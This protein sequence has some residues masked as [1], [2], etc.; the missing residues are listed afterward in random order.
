MQNTYATGDGVGAITNSHTTERTDA[1]IIWPPFLANVM[2]QPYSAAHWLAS[3]LIGQGL[4]AEVWDV[5]RAAFARMLDRDFLQA[6]Y[7]SLEARRSALEAQSSLSPD[8]VRDYNSLVS[9]LAW[10]RLILDNYEECVGRH[11]RD[12]LLYQENVPAVG[13]LNQFAQE[14]LFAS[15]DQYTEVTAIMRSVDEIRDLLR[16][17]DVVRYREFLRPMIREMI[18]TRRPRLVGLSFSFQQ[19]ALSCLVLAHE[20]AA[21]DPTIHVTIGGQIVSYLRR[22]EA[23]HLLSEDV[24]FHSVVYY[25]GEDALVAMVRALHDGKPPPELPNVWYRGAPKEGPERPH[26]NPPPPR[27]H[28]G[29]YRVPDAFLAEIPRAVRDVAWLP[30]LQAIGCYW[31]RC[32]FCDT[33]TQNGTNAL[34]APRAEKDILADIDFYYE[35]GFRRFYIVTDS[36][37]PKPALTL[38]KAIL[39]RGIDIKWT[40]FFKIDRRWD[41]ET[42][43]ALAQAGY[44]MPMVGMEHANDRVLKLIDKGYDR[45]GIVSFFDLLRQANFPPASILTILNLPTS[46]REEN[47]EV[48]AFVE[49]HA[50]RVRRFS[51]SPFEVVRNTPMAR[52]PPAFGFR[53]ADDADPTALGP[54]RNTIVLH[55]YHDEAGMTAEETLEV[56]HAFAALIDRIVKKKRYGGQGALL[57]DE[58]ALPRFDGYRFG[59][60]P[61]SHLATDVV[62]FGPDG[63]RADETD[64]LLLATLS[65]SADTKEIP[66][67]TYTLLQAFGGQELSV[68]EL[69]AGLRDTLG[70]EASEEEVTELVRMLAGEGYLSYVRS[71]DGVLHP[72]ENR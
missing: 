32:T 31:G 21:I 47:L 28:L 36:L 66:T 45:A 27:Q 29:R 69:T 26:Y 18:A 3:D 16:R 61:T 24:G 57:L 49:E 59:F 60:S 12:E 62:R 30:V 35:L 48:V 72:R 70:Y 7:A 1:L 11:P 50:D 43:S 37:P 46:T 63:Q 54:P 51:Y 67:G 5:N 56:Q 41:V 68:S 53:V 44:Q 10:L 2:R 19:Q 33:R 42:L 9:N 20:I 38:A 25:I 65:A 22:D 14:F 23:L 64:Y 4:S 34:Y 15:A 55:R 17:P 6:E 8:G 39:A 52:N 58:A 13:L 71:P 40:S